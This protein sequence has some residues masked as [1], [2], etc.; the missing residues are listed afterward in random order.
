MVKNYH[1]GDLLSPALESM[2]SKKLTKLEKYGVDPTVDIYMSME[3]KQFGMKMSLKA[4]NYELMAKSVSND[5]YKN[6]DE[7]VNK[8]AN[9]LKE[10]KVD[11]TGKKPLEFEDDV[12]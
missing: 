6:I 10:K 4:K 7:C 1:C 8:L 3:G 11:R 2:L 9:G 12:K 5:M